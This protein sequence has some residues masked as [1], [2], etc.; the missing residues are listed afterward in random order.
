MQ[1]CEIETHSFFENGQFSAKI[2]EIEAHSFFEN[3]PCSTKIGEIDAHSLLE[4][5]KRALAIL[6]LQFVD[7]K[8]AFLK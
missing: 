8:S 6:R 3:G 1:R 7:A 4:N 2:G 5:E